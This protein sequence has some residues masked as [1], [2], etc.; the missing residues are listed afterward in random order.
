MTDKSPFDLDAALAALAIDEKAAHPKVSEGLQARVLGDAAQVAAQ[1]A[2]GRTNAMAPPQSVPVPRKSARADGFRLFGLFD[3][4]SG[5]AVAT[6]ALCLI[7][8]LGLGYQAGPEL[9]AQV[10]LGGVE[11]SIVAQESDGFFLSEDVL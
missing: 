1:M 5:A 8:G 4:W 6:I 11:V 2:A 3:I 9:L 7:G 10:G